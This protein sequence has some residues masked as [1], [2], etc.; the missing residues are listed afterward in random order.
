MCRP[1]AKRSLLC[2]SMPRRVE[3]LSRRQSAGKERAVKWVFRREM[4]PAQL[5]PPV[6]DA[7]V[8]AAG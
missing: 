5:G 2:E 1:R 8:G 4:T 7:M 6:L 3:M